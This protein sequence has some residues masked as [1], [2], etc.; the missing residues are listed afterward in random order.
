MATEF[1]QNFEEI[2]RRRGI[3]PSTALKNAGLSNSLYTKWN[4]NPNTVPN[5]DTLKQIAIA[6]HVSID[7]LA[8]GDIE[9]RNIIDLVNYPSLQ[10]LLRARNRLTDTQMNEILRY[11]KYIAPEAFNDLQVL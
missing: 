10:E 11:A 1:L 6:L 8:Y 9:P 3:A 5:L 7:E 2:C 4:K